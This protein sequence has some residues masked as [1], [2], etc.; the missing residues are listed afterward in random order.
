VNASDLSYGDARGSFPD[1][2]LDIE[3]PAGPA[4]MRSALGPCALET[5]RAAP[6]HLGQEIL[7]QGEERFSSGEGLNQTNI[8]G[9][10]QL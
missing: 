10:S 7:I 9:S 4:E 8:S 2:G 6:G 3:R 5:G 1:N